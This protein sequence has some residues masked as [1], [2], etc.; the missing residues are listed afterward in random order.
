MPSAFRMF[1]ARGQP[2]HWYGY[3]EIDGITYKIDAT[4]IG[5][6]MQKHFVGT[7]KRHLKADQRELP[8]TD[9]SFVH[10]PASGVALDVSVKPI[11]LRNPPPDSSFDTT[12]MNADFD[13]SLEKL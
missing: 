9:H 2:G 3:V 8:L 10:A 4:Q 13:D 1:R 5:Q 6:R 11:E 12:A 7:V